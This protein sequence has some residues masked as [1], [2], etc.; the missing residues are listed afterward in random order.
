MLPKSKRQGT[1]AFE[2]IIKK[3]QSFHGSFLILRRLMTKQTSHFSVS[4]PKK[5][6]KS[7]VLRNKIRRRVY[8][9]IKHLEDRIR[10]DYGV[11]V[12]MKTGSEKLKFSVLS[13]EIEKI[14]VKSELLK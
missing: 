14:F 5:V 2:E 7:A 10:P 11:I 8:S 1:K 13:S 12:I 3:G 9:V 6:A 4:V